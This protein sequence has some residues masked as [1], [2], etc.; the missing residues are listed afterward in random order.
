MTC[1]SAGGGADRLGGGPGDDIL[2]GGTTAFDAN[3]QALAAIR[4]EW[5][6][7]R[8]FATRVANLSGIG[9]GPRANGNFFL[10]LDGPEATVFDDGAADVLNGAAGLDWDFTS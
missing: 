1:S 5:N 2:I 6:S 9:T 7:A 10:W 8:D 3:E 4:A